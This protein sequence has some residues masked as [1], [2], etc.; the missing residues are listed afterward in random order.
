MF[1]L[2]SRIKTVLYVELS[3]TL[4]LQLK[5]AG[6]RGIRSVLG[7]LFEISKNYQDSF[8]IAYNK[9]FMLL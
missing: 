4:K 9:I 3:T 1:V 8:H 6:I 2:L 7:G 5:V